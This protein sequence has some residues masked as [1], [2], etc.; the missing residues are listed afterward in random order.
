[1]AAQNGDRAAPGK[2]REIDAL[3]GSQPS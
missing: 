2:L 1:V 3:L